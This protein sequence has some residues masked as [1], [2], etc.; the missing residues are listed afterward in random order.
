MAGEYLSPIYGGTGQIAVTK[1][2]ILFGSANG[3][4]SRL[5]HPG[6][7]GYVLRTNA[8][9]GF[10]WTNNPVVSSLTANLSVRAGTAT[11]GNAVLVAGDET[12]TGAINFETAADVRQGY[13]GNDLSGI[14][15][16]ME[17]GVF[18]VLGSTTQVV[19]LLMPNTGGQKTAPWTAGYP[20]NTL[21]NGTQD[22]T[23]QL[24]FNITPTGRAVGTELAWYMQFEADYNDGSKRLCEW[25]LNMTTAAGVNVRPVHMEISNTNAD[26]G[27]GW[28]YWKFRA[29]E[30][31]IRDPAD[32]TLLLNVSTSGG[33]F[34][35][36]YVDSLSFEPTGSHG[37]TIVNG[38]F[39][40]SMASDKTFRMQWSDGSVSG[41]LFSISSGAS[42]AAPYVNY[43]NHRLAT[44][45]VQTRNS[46]RFNLIG[47]YW[48]GGGATEQGCYFQYF[49]NSTEPRFE[50]LD[51]SDATWFRLYQY[52]GGFAAF[53]NVDF[54][55]SATRK[56][57]PDGGG[58]TYFYESAANVLDFYAGGANTLKLT[59]TL[60]RMPLANIDF[61]NGGGNYGS[62]VT[63]VNGRTILTWED[64]T[65][66]W[67]TIGSA[68]VAGVQFSAPVGVNN[69][70]Y[71]RVQES[72]GTW[73]N[74]LGIDASEIIHIG[75][76][77]NQLNVQ[78]S[79]G[80]FTSGTPTTNG[81]IT[82]KINGTVY[83]LMTT[84]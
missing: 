62:M 24:G 19:A 13:I 20:G 46:P 83:K 64:S 12:V 51:G 17:N 70:K 33:K 36:L 23:L 16:H 78:T 75:A 44:V 34:L 76:T 35:K 58:D 6:A 31:D 15:V 27:N 73:R 77:T 30:F 41:D 65:S 63:P 74:A 39:T 61:S 54:Y 28:T 42:Y 48:N 9:D 57:Y 10:A 7:V 32:D 68:N 40:F 82:L 60:A 56:F 4:W 71:F 21:F 53:Y 2:D 37:I 1:G 45:G 14:A 81:Y 59:A 47:S 26:A 84:A 66:P 8:T 43:R 67:I 50:I 72:G 55:I 22:D 18:R 49:A 29:D 11:T 80:S 3:V 69:T 25:H 5:A 52:T 38:D 79:D